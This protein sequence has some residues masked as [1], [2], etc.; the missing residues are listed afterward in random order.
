MTKSV[1]G[2]LRFISLCGCLVYL[3]VRYDIGV[4]AYIA[5]VL[6]A[7]TWGLTEYWEGLCK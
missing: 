7:F 5:V 6:V 3:N 2:I 4:L 1:C